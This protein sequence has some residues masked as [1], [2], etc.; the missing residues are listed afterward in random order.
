MTILK[1]IVMR[2]Y[3]STQASPRTS[4]LD[5]FM[6]VNP[7]SPPPAL[8]EDMYCLIASTPNNVLA[9]GTVVNLVASIAHTL[10]MGEGIYTVLVNHIINES[11]RLI[12]PVDD[13]ITIGEAL[14]I[15]Y[16]LAYFA[17]SS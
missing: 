5:S 7:A 11:V 12:F 9:H 16:S 6:G 17:C 2:G 1:K 4:I 8:A 15:Y 3:R 14:E 13:R 10:S